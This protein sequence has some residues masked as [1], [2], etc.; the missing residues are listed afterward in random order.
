V[1]GFRSPSFRK[2]LDASYSLPATLAKENEAERGGEA[3][4]NNRGVLPSTV[5]ACQSLTWLQVHS[6][7]LRRWTKRLYW[8][9]RRPHHLLR[10][11]AQNKA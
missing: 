11:I 9:G 1:R 8:A 5:G 4:D 6:F 10:H 3:E 2:P 7:L